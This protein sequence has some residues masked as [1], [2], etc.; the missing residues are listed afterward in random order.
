MDRKMVVLIAVFLVFFGAFITITVFNSNISSLTRATTCLPDPAKSPIFVWPL[1]LN[2]H[3]ETSSISIF[4][5]DQNSLPCAKKNVAL[6][7]SMGSLR[8]TLATTDNNGKATFIYSCTAQG[9]AQ[10]S[11]TI[12]NTTAIAQTVTI[13]CQ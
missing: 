9:E 5:R 12:D 1:Q 3:E 13:L 4:V 2:D 8:Q 10:I 11:A 6:A 7:T